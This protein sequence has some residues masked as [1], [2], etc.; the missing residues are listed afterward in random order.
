MTNLQIQLSWEDPATG[1]RREPKLNLPI[2][3]GREFAKLPTEIRGQRV[4]RMLLNSNE[5]SRYHAL[6]DW[7]QDWDQNH[8]VVIDQNSVNGVY[9]NGQRQTRCQLANGDT[10]QIGPYIITVQFGI[11]SVIPTPNNPSTIQFNPQTN[12]PDPSLS[13]VRPVT[14]LSSN[15]PPPAFQD[16]KVDLQA[17]HATGL[18]VD[19]CDYLAVGAGLGSFIW[20]DL[21]RI[22]GVKAE[23]II[24]VGLEAEPYAR[25]KRLCLNSQIPLHERLRSN[26]DSCPDNIWGWPSYALRESWHDLT[27]GKLNLAFKYLWQVFNEPTFAETYTPRAG[28]VFDS[29]DRETKR[30]GWNQ[31]YRYGRVRAIRKTEDGRYCVA[32]SRGQGNYAFLVCRYLHLA[33][34]YPAIQ[35]LPDL[36]AYREKY[37]DFKLVVNAYE[38]HNHVYEQ[39]EKQGGTVLIRGRGIVASRILQRIYEVRQQNRN[40]TVLH[41]MRSPKPQGNKFQKATRLVKNHYEFQPFNWPKACWGGELR[42]MLEKAT[43]EE[44][45]RLLADWGGTTTADRVDWQKITEQGIKEGW[46]QIT[47]GQVLGVEQDGKNHT[48][49]HIQEK[50]FG[51]MKL[52]ADFII[53]ATGLDAKVNANPLLEDVVTHY[54]LPLNHLGRLVVANNFELVEMRN[55]KGQVYAAGAITLGG[56]YAAVDSFLGLQYAALVAVD[57]LYNSRAP[58]VGRLNTFGSLNQWIK[59]VFNQSPHTN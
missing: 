24:A 50:G 49:T 11:N 2:A 32:Y 30:I 18:P 13:P 47:F 37:Q 16:T 12:L 25:Y 53:D 7:E 3:F 27:N 19:E 59:W 43:P 26:S 9:V 23:K 52:T 54:N 46:Y 1:E 34:G 21:L 51:E 31:I 45:Q 48:I 40:I 17:I 36:Q 57:G 56:P 39:L 28:N 15:F 33:T 29:I 8:F 42:E 58:G 5:V 44:R 38:D 10:L 41:L 4:S 55:T 14:P 20:V 35:F 22:S 6:I